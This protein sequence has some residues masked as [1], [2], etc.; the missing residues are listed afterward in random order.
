M[1]PTLYDILGVS[2]AASRE[3]IRKAWRDAAD[4][5]E[6]GE[7]GSTKQF[8]LFN[9]AAEVLL[10]PERRKAYDAQLETRPAADADSPAK[11]DADSPAKAAE[12]SPAEAAEDSPSEG[13]AATVAEDQSAERTTPTPPLPGA[14]RAVTGSTSTPAVEPTD[15]EESRTGRLLPWWVLAVLGVLTAVAIGFA[16]YFVTQA[17]RAEAYQDA[18]DRAT[19]AAENAAG[20]VLSY[21]HESLEA[22]RDAAAKFLTDEYRE[23]YVDTYE[24]VLEGA[25][26]QKST[27]EAEVMASAPMVVGEGRDPDR[28]SVLVFVDQ[29][30]V[31]ADSPEPNRFL[32]RAQFDM[33]NVDGTW[34]V[35]GITSY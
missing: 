18:L 12:D 35:D 27:V 7:G 29:A 2:R 34:L 20:P 8:R 32:N 13:G 10:D 26:Q 21:S 4:R 5:F 22:D 25:P 24:L 30:T 3:E 17:N 33:V 14:A 11:A 23:K 9:E 16:A 31:N 15:G 6:P 1:N 19:S 28:V